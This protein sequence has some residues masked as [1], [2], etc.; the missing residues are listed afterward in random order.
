MPW[1]QSTDYNLAIQNP[2]LCFEDEEL[3]ASTAFSADP[4]LGLPTPRAGNFADVYHMIHP[5][6]RQ[7]AVKCF[8]REVEDLHDRYA[9]ISAYLANSPRSFIIEFRYLDTGILIDGVWYPVLK[10]RWIEGKTLNEF[11]RENADK[12]VLLDKLAL[13]WLKLAQD[14]RD[15]GIGHGDLQH[16]NVLLVP[17]PQKASMH[18]R[19]ID[20]DG[21]Y[22]PA[23]ANCPSREKGFPGFQHPRRSPRQYGPE[24]DRFSHL[25]IFT[26]LRA[27]RVGGSKLWNNFGTLENLLFSES[28]FTLPARS[29]LLRTLFATLD[30]PC[31]HLV[32]HLV[33]A[34]V[35]DVDRVPLLSEVAPGGVIRRLENAEYE[36]LREIVGSMLSSQRRSKIDNRTPAPRFPS[37]TGGEIPT[38]PL[39]LPPLPAPLRGATRLEPVIPTNGSPEVLPIPV[40]EARRLEENGLPDWMMPEAMPMQESLVRALPADDDDDEPPLALPPLML[41]PLPPVDRPIPPVPRLTPVL[42]EELEARPLPERDKPVEKP[43]IAVEE[44]EENAPEARPAPRKSKLDK[45]RSREERVTVKPDEEGESPQD[46]SGI[47]ILLA[48]AIVLICAVLG[49]LLVLWLRRDPVP[50]SGP[51]LPDHATLLL[52]SEVRLEGGQQQTYTLRFQRHIDRSP[53]VVRVVDLPAPLELK[54]VTAPEPTETPGI[55]SVSCT[56]AAP[57]DVPANGLLTATVQLLQNERMVDQQPL[58]IRLTRVQLPTLQ[59]QI[60]RHRVEIGKSEKLAFPI[61]RHGRTERLRVEF[62]GLPDG[63]QQ[64]P[65]EV[66]PR[67]TQA[68]VNVTVPVRQPP[69][70]ASVEVRLWLIPEGPTGGQPFVVDQRRGVGL[71]FTRPR[72]TKKFLTAPAGGVRIE[73]GK[74]AE[75]RVAIDRQVVSA[76]LVLELRNLPPGVTASEVEVP[77]S[78]GSGLFLLTATGDAPVTVVVSLIVAREGLDEIGRISNPVRVVP[79]TGPR[80]GGVAP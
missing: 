65:V 10:M 68:V 38:T 56:L 39:D 40:P 78:N 80:P 62:V 74:T 77:A 2:H 53:F 15:L 3:R 34:A 60:P 51:G 25:V 33:L 59:P 41:V 26:A 18:L 72:P 24:I 16:G 9:A 35:G 61:E 22:V 58:H 23:L 32:G 79:A 29:D 67:E 48:A 50:P 66:G 4:V 30:V 31:R 19:L 71:D 37:Q 13:M 70:S 52:P 44:V 6:G 17:N 21:M 69:G 36:R 11:V 5:D 47:G 75:L 27:L 55:Q 64:T 1:P 76:A 57:L 49:G 45:S 46:S 28:D 42:L 73:V 43:A 7:W 8:T 54:S 63:V 20:Y 14:L 12:P